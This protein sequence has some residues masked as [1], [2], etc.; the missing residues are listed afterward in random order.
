M[1][2]SVPAVTHSETKTQLLVEQAERSLRNGD[3]AGAGR[4][5]AEIAESLEEHP[6]GQLAMART[7]IANGRYADSEAV[8][9][10]LDVE[11]PEEAEVDIVRGTLEEARGRWEA[12]RIAYTKAV[13]KSPNSVTP[14]LLQSKVDL[15]LGQP[16]RAAAQLERSL[17]RLPNVLQLQEAL[18]EA[19]FAAG[20]YREASQWYRTCLDHDQEARHVRLR[21]S[22]TL[23]LSGEH[24]EALRAARRLSDSDVPPYARLALGRSALIV[25]EARD[26]AHWLSLY[27]DEYPDDGSAWLDLARAYYLDGLGHACLDAIRNS[28]QLEPGRAEAYILLGH[29][30]LKHEQHDMALKSYLEG[31]RLGADGSGIAELLEAL[32]SRRARE[33][34]AIKPAEVPAKTLEEQAVALQQGAGA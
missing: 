33:A 30:R 1:E 5:L 29:L 2:D 26:A 17:A 10:K 21:Y 4:S 7:L 3:A 22:F 15:I 23:S 9:D 6:R 28:L 34:E 12:A 16:G 25:N 31:V 14:I 20:E 32:F 24:A 18:A 8:L 11:L 27:V 19:Y 13:E